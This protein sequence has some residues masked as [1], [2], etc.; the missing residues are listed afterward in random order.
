MSR[1]ATGWLNIKMKLKI[2]RRQ[3][4]RGRFHLHHPE[5]NGKREY[6]KL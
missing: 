2:A 6:P 1:L 5:E 3:F 4:H